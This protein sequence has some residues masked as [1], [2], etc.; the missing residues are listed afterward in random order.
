MRK[1]LCDVCS[2]EIGNEVYCNID[3]HIKMTALENYEDICMDCAIKLNTFL[4]KLKEEID[5]KK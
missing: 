4:S 1:F 3:F 2:R 5:T